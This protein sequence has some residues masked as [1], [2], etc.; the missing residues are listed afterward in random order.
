MWHVVCQ[1]HSYSPIEHLAF[2]Q[3]EARYL[4]YGDRPSFPLIKK[5]LHKVLNIGRFTER[6]KAK[7]LYSEK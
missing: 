4:R 1:Y 7:Q 5:E 3:P 2:E 6:G